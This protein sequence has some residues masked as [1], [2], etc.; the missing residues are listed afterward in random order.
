MNQ[1]LRV[2][3]SLALGLAVTLL[4]GELMGY[5]LDA[6]AAGRNIALMNEIATNNTVIDS[7]ELEDK[8]R[9]EGLLQPSNSFE[10]GGLSNVRSV[11][12]WYPHIFV[13][14]IL[15]CL[16]IFRARSLETLIFGLSFGAGLTLW[17]GWSVGLATIVATMI[18]V[19][20]AWR[21][22][23]RSGSGQ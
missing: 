9:K 2:I 6:D 18:Y 10:R 11:I 5:P 14:S 17:A 22:E 8:Y 13:I 20:Y 12:M 23:R 1:I 15:G 19:G 21:S 4:I 3:A 16:L 7:D